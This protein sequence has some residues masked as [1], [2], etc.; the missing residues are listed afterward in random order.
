MTS[1]TYFTFESNLLAALDALAALTVQAVAGIIHLL[2]VVVRFLALAVVENYK[3][4]GTLVGIIA[5]TLFAVTNPHIVAAL[6]LIALF[7]YTYYPEN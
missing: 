7:A 5:L 2:C 6:A 3:L 1:A 4:V